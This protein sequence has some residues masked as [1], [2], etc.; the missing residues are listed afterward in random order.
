MIRK[1]LTISSVGDVSFSTGVEGHDYDFSNWISGEVRDFLK[2]DIQIGNLECVFYPKGHIRPQG[3]NLAEQDSS[4][5]AILT[6][7]FDVLSLANNHICD[8]FG[9]KGIE[10]TIAILDK[11]N[12]HHCGAGLNLQEAKKPTIIALNGY[13]VGVFG[14]V[15]EGSFENISRDIATEVSA[16]VAPLDIEEIITAAEAAK[17]RFDL[18]LVVLCVHWGIQDTHNH[19]S[20][21]DKI[22]NAIVNE[23]NVDIILG[24]H[25]HCIQ[26]ISSINNK[27]ICY[28]QGNFYFYP[29]LLDEGILYPEGQ[30]LNRTSLV[31]KVNFNGNTRNLTVEARAVTQNKENVVVFLDAEK[32]AKKLASASLKLPG[33]ASIPAF[34]HTGKL[35]RAKVIL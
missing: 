32:E 7:G 33:K 2:S 35:D 13:K 17:Q 4:A 5:E 15:H 28:G 11:N 26:G 24:S 23:S 8:Y 18:D 21:I 16:G 12:I 3:F 14:R 6:S 27:V 22:A 19:T 34:L 10:H 25:S 9:F 1:N 30:D 29:Q 31:T 20:E